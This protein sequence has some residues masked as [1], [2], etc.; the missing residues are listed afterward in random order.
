M[1]ASWCN[2]ARARFT[3]ATMSPATMASP[4]L[5]VLTRVLLLLWSSPRIAHASRRDAGGSAAPPL[6]LIS[7]DGL[8]ADYLTDPPARVATPNFDAIKAE[9]VHV[10]NGMTPAFV[11]K[12]FPNHWTLVTGRFEESQ[13]IVGNRMRDPAL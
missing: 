10:R 4:L 1:K 11:S 13:G 5:R 7:F 2:G 9:G 12:T 6:L 3:P 8:R